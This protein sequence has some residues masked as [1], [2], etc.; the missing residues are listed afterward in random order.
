[1]HVNLEQCKG[2]STPFKVTAIAELCR[3]PSEQLIKHMEGALICKDHAEVKKLSGK[4][5]NGI[6]IIIKRKWK[7]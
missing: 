6:I 7:M 5:G 3:S 1:M 4:D 2:S